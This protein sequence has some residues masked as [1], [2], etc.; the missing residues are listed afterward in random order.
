MTLPADSSV[1]TK[2]LSID[3]SLFIFSIIFLH[4]LFDNCN[5]WGW[6]KKS[7]KMKIFLLFS[8]A[9]AK[10]NTNTVKVTHTF[11]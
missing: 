3:H 7:I 2:V 6:L 10:M 1:P 9:Y 5:Y 8:I 11:P 4:L